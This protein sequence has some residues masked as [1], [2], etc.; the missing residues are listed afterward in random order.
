MKNWNTIEKTI[1]DPAAAL[2]ENIG[3]ES[4]SVCP[5]AIKTY[6]RANPLNSAINKDGIISFL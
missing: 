5:I 1:Y 2:D 4:E 6:L 3:M